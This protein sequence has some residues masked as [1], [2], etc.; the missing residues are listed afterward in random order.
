MNSLRIGIAGIT[1]RLGTLC[2]EEVTACGLML[3]GGLS[4]RADPGRG[5]ETDPRVLAAR[6][7]V[8]IDVSHA[9]TVAAHAAAFAEAGC[10][11]VLGTTGL[12]AAGREA[13][14][15]AAARIPVLQA[16]NFSPALSV[17]L[18]LARELGAALPEYDAEIVETHHRQKVDAPSGTARAIGEAV[19]SGRGVALDDVAEIDRNRRRG[20]GA[21]GF[22]SLRSGQIVGE[23]ALSFTSADEQIVLS[24]RAF[25][26]RLFAR[27]AVRA[28]RFLAGRGA[29]LYGM[30]D[31]V[32]GVADS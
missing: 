11:W 22:A 10:G 13:V 23:H 5:I 15:R 20:E 31:A 21:I 9:E 16:A 1:G 12:D 27:G 3:A 18:R 8:V 32:R 29:G 28:A 6:C 24:H 4:R 19:A 17:L 30:E 2:A 25:D 7:D 14:G 26:R